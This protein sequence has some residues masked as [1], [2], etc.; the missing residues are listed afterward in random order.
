MK[1]LRN[2]L[3]KIK[4]HFQ[5]GGRFEMFHS[6]FDAFE[7]FLFVPNTVTTK[8][9][10]IRDSL[11]LKR[12]MSI[13]IIAL[14]PAMLFG[15][16]NV[17]YQHALSIGASWGFLETFWYG[18]LKVLPLI[19][20]SY[21]VGLSIEFA[22]AQ[23][24]GH[25]VNEG[26]LVSGLLIPLIMPVD[27]PLWM[28]AIAV[29]FAVIIGKEVF[30]GTGYNV[31]NPALLARAFLF[32]AYPSHMSG[33]KVWI[34]GLTQGKGVVD[35]FSGATPLAKAAAYQ[36]DQL[37]SVYD[38]FMGFIPGSVGETST[39]AI[40]IG[41]II[42][43]VTGIG[44]WKIMVSV[45]GGGL[46]A[47]LLFNA[48][49]VNPYMEIPAWQHLIMGGF[50]FGAVFM[51]TDPVSASQTEKGKW[52]YGFLVGFLALLVRVLNPAYPEGM[53]LAILLMNAFAPLID[54]YVVEANIRRRM[55][56]A[57]KVANV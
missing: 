28:L 48:F 36:I 47:G 37:P 8:G 17:G 57:K 31:F 44:S 39:L 45:F 3:D 24:R 23:S 40:L 16:W 51:A 6:T 4:P 55:K 35:G 29:A 41:A 38:M 49:A 32:F 19:V 13:V 11:D 1:A 2:Y 18:F 42:L 9:S 54:Y 26:F 5:K 34:A 56:R 12:T 25:E 14:M 21:G 7:T 20:V 33:D 46:A 43:I 52:I 15:M 50:A 10:H 27:V 22:F 53:M 30:G